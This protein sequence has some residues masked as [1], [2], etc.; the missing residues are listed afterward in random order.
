MV[1]LQDI[2]VINMNDSQYGEELNNRLQA[3]DSNFD[4]LLSTDFLRGAQGETTGTL[5]I[6]LGILGDTSLGLYIEKSGAQTE[7]ILVTMTLILSQIVSAIN[8]IPSATYT[9]NELLGQVNSLGL[10]G[11]KL[12]VFYKTVYINGQEKKYLVSSIPFAY[13]DPIYNS[14]IDT[15]AI[16]DPEDLNDRSCVVAYND[17]IHSFVAMHPF[18]QIYY[19]TE[20]GGGS[21]CWKINGQETSIPCQGPIGKT[22][23]SSSLYIAYVNNEDSSVEGLT[24][25]EIYGVVKPIPNANLDEGHTVTLIESGAFGSNSIN[26]KDGDIAICLPVE[27]T[28]VSNNGTTIDRYTL[29][30]PAFISNILISEVVGD[31]GTKTYSYYAIAADGYINNLTPGNLNAGSHLFESLNTIGI[32]GEGDAAIVPKGL[33]IPAETGGN[34]QVPTV[35]S[36]HMMWNDSTN[37]TNS[38]NI[39]PVTNVAN[40][41]SVQS[42]KTL[43]VKYDTSK[44]KDIV[45]ANIT[46]ENIIGESITGDTAE[47]NEL[48]TANYVEAKTLRVS[49]KI[50]SSL[51]IDGTLI[52]GPDQRND[53]KTY[54]PCQGDLSVQQLLTFVEEVNY[55]ELVSLRDDKKLIPGKFYRITDYS[56][57]TSQNGTSSAG[58]PF[59]VIVLALSNDKLSE[60]AWAMHSTRDT[61]GY[62]A[63]SKLEAWKIWYC[64]DNDTNRFAWACDDEQGKGVIYRMIDEFGNDC[65]YDFKNILMETENRELKY[66]FHGGYDSKVIPDWVDGDWSLHGPKRN[67]IGSCED[68]LIP[69]VFFYSYITTGWGASEE[70][71]HDNVVLNSSYVKIRGN[72]N[73]VNRSTQVDIIG[74]NCNIPAGSKNVSINRSSVTYLGDIE[75]YDDCGL[76]NNI[77]TAGNQIMIIPSME[78]ID[79]ELV[80]VGN[81]GGLNF[82]IDEHVTKI[83]NEKSYHY[84]IKIPQNVSTVIMYGVITDGADTYIALPLGVPTGHTI[85][86][87]GNSD[88]KDYRIMANPIY[89]AFSTDSGIGQYIYSGGST[90]TTKFTASTTNPI[91]WDESRYTQ[92]SL[93]CKYVELP[94]R[95]RKRFTYV[96]NNPNNDKEVGTWI[97]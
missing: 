32:W 25:R 56:T 62:F 90:N 30:A 14:G 33:F 76:L 69:K 11:R 59:D 9:E 23:L 15:T 24:L 50:E 3:I 17:Q 43:N 81:Y 89:D 28:T 80:I 96:G 35:E 91:I 27:K 29:V 83:G 66:T 16:E 55:L 72:N 60:E 77:R 49:D 40:P 26:I 92:G 48:L 58:H 38:L 47:I 5:E 70:I 20:I 19:D 85:E 2:E 10:N 79:N 36:Y 87:M 57:T 94:V 63:D 41:S 7:D 46:G 68:G 64:L 93:Y 4:A 52:L 97:G 86:F 45:S 18:P 42:D 82:S 6:T 34:A 61:N 12:V 37:D 44:F 8:G 54:N 95:T 51:E 21:L 13:Y 88:K 1:E 39:G 73:T 22:G 67:K 71:C 75:T 78:V 74:D 65:P 53:N 31:G 84:C